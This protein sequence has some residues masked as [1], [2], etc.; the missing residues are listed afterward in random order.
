MCVERRLKPTREEGNTFIRE[1]VRGFNAVIWLPRT[2]AW[3]ERR[4]RPRKRMRS[5]ERLNSRV[6]L[7][8]IDR[9]SINGGR[10]SLEPA[11]DRVRLQRRC[12]EMF[13]SMRKRSTNRS[14]ADPRATDQESIA[15]GIL[16]E[17]I[18]QHQEALKTYQPGQEQMLLPIVGMYEKCLQAFTK[19]G[20]P[21]EWARVNG[22]LGGV[23]GKIPTGD[24]KADSA[25]A[26]EFYEAA[27]RVYRE[28]AFPK[29]WAATQMLL[30]GVHFRLSVGDRP[31]HLA[32]AI[33]HYDAA[34]RVWDEST[35]PHDWATAQASVGEA[36]RILGAIV[37]GTY[38][39]RAIDC[40]LS[41][42]RIWTRDAF[43]LKWAEM[44][45]S[46]VNTYQDL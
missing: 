8:K 46:L 23:F 29:Q 43:P 34:L 16:Q 32:K 19:T 2:L 42:Q 1:T 7:R 4:A 21:K 20:S 18:S 26:I 39:Y 36:C 25:R 41:A 28:D 24:H 14:G 31:R 44:Q 15:L 38:A 22:L 33:K 3:L 37:G 17:A 13:S 9:I 6:L 40:Y 45:Q 5:S 27:L 12:I 30:G 10:W 35:T 11:T